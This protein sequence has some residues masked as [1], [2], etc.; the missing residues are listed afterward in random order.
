MIKSYPQNKKTS[1]KSEKKRQKNLVQKSYI[2]DNVNQFEELTKSVY[3]SL[4]G[5]K[6]K[7]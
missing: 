7:N 4:K 2:I 1:S 3:G 6:L 5:R